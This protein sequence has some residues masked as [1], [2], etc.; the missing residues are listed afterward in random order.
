[1]ARVSRPACCCLALTLLVLSV[2]ALGGFGY[3]ATPFSIT[4][5][6]VSK[7]LAFVTALSL[8]LP[9]WF[10]PWRRH[11]P[12]ITETAIASRPPQPEGARR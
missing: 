11:Q 7:I 2:W 10:T 6:A 9:E 1:M 4:M 5:N 12:K 3:P 8:L